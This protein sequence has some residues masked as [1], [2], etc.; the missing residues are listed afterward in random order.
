VG[1]VVYVRDNTIAK[2]LRKYIMR[3]VKINHRDNC[4]TVQATVAHSPYLH[5]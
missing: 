4:L 2:D 1:D 5:I 3:K